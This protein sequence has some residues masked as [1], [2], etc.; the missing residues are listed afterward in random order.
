MADDQT[1]DAPATEPEGIW[2]EPEGDDGMPRQKAV[3]LAQFGLIA[4]VVLIV[5]IVLVAQSGK[6]D[7]ASSSDKTSTD[8]G[9][10]ATTEAEAAKKAVWPA[11]VQGRPAGLGETKQ[12]A[13][14]V[15]PTAAPGAYIWS[16]F[17]GWHLW[18]VN[19]EGMPAV[20][21]TLTSNADIE[22]AVV[23]VPEAGE[24]TISGKTA[25]FS[26]PTDRPLVG[27]DF[28]PGFY[29]D[30]L[31]VA[32]NGPDGAPIA[33]ELVQTG[34]KPTPAPFPIVID[35]AVPES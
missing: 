6:D 17:D 7:D 15:Q 29:A 16:D 27:M 23:A 14:E 35:K 34:K 3:R 25:T 31:V 5:G 24:V 21:G 28:N 10:T 1:N 20:T 4:L 26:F 12:P 8:G 2:T 32:L 11:T 19:G 18:V 13:T 9:S 22:K 33:A 30:S